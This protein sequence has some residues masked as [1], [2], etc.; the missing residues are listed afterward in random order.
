MERNQI[1]DLE[2]LVN[3]EDLDDGD[4][5]YLTDNPIDCE[6]QADNIDE[7]EDRGVDLEVDC[8]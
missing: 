7:L 6:D 8:D 2:P 3:N 1:S 4:S 5:V